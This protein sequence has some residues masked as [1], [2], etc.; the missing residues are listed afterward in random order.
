VHDNGYVHKGIYEGWY[1][2]RC[3]DFKTESE[4]GPDNTCL[5]HEIPLVREKEE[6]WFFELSRFQEPLERLYA[7]RDD[8]VLPRTRANEAQSFIAR[9]SRTS[10][11]PVRA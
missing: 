1:C 7:E 2:P 6:N 9:A 3:A 5:I 11:S 8:F 4:I 10:R